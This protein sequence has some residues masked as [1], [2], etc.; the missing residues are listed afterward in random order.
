[1]KIKNLE[2]F[3]TVTRTRHQSTTGRSGISVR[4]NVP[5]FADLQPACPNL[6]TR[7][8]LRRASLSEI[9]TQPRPI[10]VKF[11]PIRGPGSGGI[12]GGPGLSRECHGSFYAL[13]P[14]TVTVT[15]PIALTL[16]LPV[17]P[18][19]LRSAG[20]LILIFMIWRQETRKAEDLNPTKIAQ[21]LLSILFLVKFLLY[22][23]AKYFSRGQDIRRC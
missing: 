23:P 11:C 15:L 10:L 4:I 18:F 7:R 8:R 13:P 12:M 3:A 21:F 5:G 22:L 9:L 20:S 16:K 14:A 6:F 17:D 19:K 1:M 2:K